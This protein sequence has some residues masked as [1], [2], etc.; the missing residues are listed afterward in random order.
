VSA[1]KSNILVKQ[2]FKVLYT[3]ANVRTQLGYLIDDTLLQLYVEN[4]ILNY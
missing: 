1:R 4:K 3:G 2:L